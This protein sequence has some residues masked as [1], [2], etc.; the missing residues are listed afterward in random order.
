MTWKPILL[1]GTFGAA[2]MLWG[3][4][5]CLGALVSDLVPEVVA[6]GLT[7]GVAVLGSA[8]ASRAF[9]R[10][11]DRPTRRLRAAAVAVALALALGIGL[12]LVF[13]LRRYSPQ[14]MLLFSL[15]AAA[16]TVL[17]RAGRRSPGRIAAA[18]SLAAVLLAASALATVPRLQ[19]LLGSARGC[20]TF[21]S[22]LDGTQESLAVWIRACE[23]GSVE[24]CVVA[25]SQTPES[26]PERR[27]VYLRKACAGGDDVSCRQAYALDAF[28]AN[29]KD[30]CG[31]L[32]LDACLTSRDCEL[33]QI[34][35]GAPFEYICR[36][37][38]NHCDRDIA[39]SSSAEP[40]CGT[41]P[42]CAYRP[43]HC[44]IVGYYET[45]VPSGQKP[46]PGC[47]CRGGPAEGCVDV[48]TPFQPGEDP[49]FPWEYD[50]APSGSVGSAPP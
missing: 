47:T 2:L 21:G 20:D 19:C 14:V 8:A 1:A 34:G 30:P 50:V 37:P 26:E 25:A 13:V 10:E 40:T 35:K 43:A 48:H 12:P 29:E 5:L 36:S 3:A 15:P 11:R 41:R 24:G 23:L 4:G 38:K 22:M 45:R 6:Y 33:E 32:A 42:G 27:T 49:V 7:L 28:L 18:A 31:R 44:C 16:L 17:V 46:A 9:G 39:Q